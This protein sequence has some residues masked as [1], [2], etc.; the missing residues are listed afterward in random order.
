MGVRVQIFPFAVLKGFSLRDSLVHSWSCA[1]A[2][3]NIV[4][5]CVVIFIVICNDQLKVM[6]LIIKCIFHS[7]LKALVLALLPAPEHVTI[8]SSWS[9]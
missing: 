1:S 8:G 6:S 4:K 2:E 5:N 3:T 9:L 7:D